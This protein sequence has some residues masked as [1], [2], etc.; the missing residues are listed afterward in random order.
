MVPFLFTNYPEG[1]DPS[2]YNI[3]TNLIQD[4]NKKGSKKISRGCKEVFLIDTV[5]VKVKQPEKEK[6]LY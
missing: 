3:F 1:I 6:S 2:T 5:T 4:H